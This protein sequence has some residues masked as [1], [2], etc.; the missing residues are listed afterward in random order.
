MFLQDR[1]ADLKLR[2]SD[3]T[4]V[5]VW[6]LKEAEVAAVSHCPDNYPATIVHSMKV[7]DAIRELSVLLNTG[8]YIDN[9][10]D[11]FFDLCSPRLKNRIRYLRNNAA[12]VR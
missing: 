6:W 2:N 5:E 12:G 11:R 1:D 4:S 7:T 3:F 8:W 9:L 10:S